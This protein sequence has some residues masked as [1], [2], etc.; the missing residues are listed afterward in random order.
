[1]HHRVLVVAAPEAIDRQIDS[2]LALFGD[3]ILQLFRI[4]NPHIEIA[5]GHQ[6]D[7]VD[8]VFPEILLLQRIGQRQAFTARGRAA[9]IQR[10]QGAADLEFLVAAGR[11][12]HRAGRSRIGDQ[13]DTVLG[14]ELLH[15]DVE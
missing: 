4:G 9:G 7:A 5:I 12:Q 1:M 8:G 15:Q 10:L 13:R 6:D 3:E 11:T 14:P 2:G